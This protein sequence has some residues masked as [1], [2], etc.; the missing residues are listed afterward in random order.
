MG[1]RLNIQIQREEE[2][3]ANAYYHW[4]AYTMS[5]LRL[6]VM[7]ED[8]WEELSSEPDDLI[9]AVRLLE[10]TGAGLTD[11][12]LKSMELK[13]PHFSTPKLAVS[14]NDGLI[15]ISVQGIHE[16]IDWAEGTAIISLEDGSVLFNVFD[17]YDDEEQIIEAYD[18]SDEE[19]AGAPQL[20]FDEVDLHMGKIKEFTANFSDEKSLY[21]FKNGRFLSLIC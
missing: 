6:L 12:E 13:R 4:S 15:A 10:T 11:E 2:I 19:I 20:D 17:E 18:P 3:I 8:K 5:S 16:T 21:K 14:R 7:I 9:R 1:Q